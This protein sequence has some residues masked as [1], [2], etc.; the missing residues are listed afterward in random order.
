MSITREPPEWYYNVRASEDGALVWG[1]GA[2]TEISPKNIKGNYYSK[3]ITI[4]IDKVLVVDDH[5]E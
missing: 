3:I 1:A 2:K 5:A 4:V